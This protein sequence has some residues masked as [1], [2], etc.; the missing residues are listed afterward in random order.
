MHWKGTGIRKDKLIN[1]FENNNDVH[2]R[3]FT[4][5]YAENRLLKSIERISKEEKISTYPFDSLCYQVGADFFSIDGY[6]S[7]EDIV[8]ITTLQRKSNQNP[9]E[10]KEEEKNQE[11]K[12]LL[13]DIKPMT[14]KEA[15]EKYEETQREK[16]KKEKDSLIERIM[17]DLG[18]ESSI[19][20]ILQNF[21]SGISHLYGGDE[22]KGKE[23]FGK[24]LSRIWME[25][26]KGIVKD[27]C[28]KNFIKL[29]SIKESTTEISNLKKIY[30]EKV[31]N[32]SQ[33]EIVYTVLMGM[34]CVADSI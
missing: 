13:K 23:K 8:K 32:L 12:P 29:I 22:E 34:R 4:G 14:L 11:V 26:K 9:T 6:V 7:I 21:S 15:K 33:K 10:N 19:N 5:N 2:I 18:E 30:I 16:Q 17:K 3:E 31:K 28:W 25:G 1:M 27:K 20:T 24:Y